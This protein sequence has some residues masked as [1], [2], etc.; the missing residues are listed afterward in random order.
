MIERKNT[1][2][3]IQKENGGLHQE[4]NTKRK[5][6]CVSEEKWSVKRAAETKNVQKD[7]QKPVLTQKSLFIKEKS[8]GKS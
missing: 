7:Q 5:L 1:L 6:C 3:E 4:N 8:R 2:V